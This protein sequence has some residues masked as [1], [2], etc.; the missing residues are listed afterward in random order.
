MVKK[1]MMYSGVFDVSIDR[2]NKCQEKI[3]QK[4][5]I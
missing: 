1:L 5:N 2:N 3:W 4:K